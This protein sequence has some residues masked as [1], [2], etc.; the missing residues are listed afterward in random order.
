MSISFRWPL[1]Q[2]YRGALT[3]VS[4]HCNWYLL[5]NHVYCTMIYCRINFWSWKL[6]SREPQPIREGVPYVTF[7]FTGWD[8]SHVDLQTTHPR[9]DSHPDTLMNWFPQLLQWRQNK[10]KGVSNHRHI[11]CLLNSLFR[12]KR[13]VTRKM[14]PFNDVIMVH[15]AALTWVWFGVKPC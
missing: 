8:R 15:G 13:A 10:R 11:D 14:F 12:R 1:C 2:R 9:N 7:S 6:R 4:W 5:C 3:G